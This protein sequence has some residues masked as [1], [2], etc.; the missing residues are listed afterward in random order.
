MLCID[1]KNARPFTS[2]VIDEIS[3]PFTCLLID[4]VRIVRVGSRMR[5]ELLRRPSSHL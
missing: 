1:L 3:H 2:R 5:I 4:Q